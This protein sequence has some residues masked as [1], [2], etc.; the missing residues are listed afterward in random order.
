M[1][2]FDG[3]FVLL[4]VALRLASAETANVSFAALACYALLG[5][6]R[7]IQALL[8]SWLFVMLNPGISPTPSVAGVGRYGVLLCAAISVLL[9]SGILTRH[10]RM[11]P[12]TR[13][14][15]L[16]GGFFVFHSIA[17]SPFVDVSVLKSASWMIAT[18]TL[19]SGWHSLSVDEHKT[20]STQVFVGLT[21]LMLCSLPFLLLPQ[22]YLV[23]G[24][25]FQ[26]VL[27]H[28]QA[29][30][31]TMALLGAWAVGHIV[32]NR[33]ETWYFTVLGATCLSLIV[34]SEARTAGFG[35]ILGCMFAV[36]ITPLL[37]R[38]R[39]RVVLRGLL[40]RRVQI[41]LL[42]LLAGAAM[43][44][45]LL[46]SRMVQYVE[47]RS[48]ADDASEA[49]QISRG[50]LI[51]QMWINIQHRPL[52]GIGFGIASSPNQMVVEREP[53][54]GFPVSAAI[55]KGVLPLAVLEEVGVIGALAVAVWLFTLLRRSA[56]GGVITMAVVMTV[57]SMN[58]GESTLFSPGGFG[59]LPLALLGWAASS[60]SV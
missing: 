34:A 4:V 53:V 25:G 56:S 39:T 12:M 29:F 20:L 6:A 37:S 17:T 57:L 14:T 45:P 1:K 15:M 10:F 46:E 47:K 27:S 32:G 58:M 55:E 28:P 23:N 8:L 48:E 54:L 52:L 49:Y 51:Q 11:H 42:I 50:G 33:S 13:A 40:S 22:G 43:A 41:L 35:L 44:W 18:S 24:T 36:I 30:G 16:L 3:T 9:R 19:I 59:L 21:I 26:G 31:P 7:A 2:W 38:S 5:R 60:R